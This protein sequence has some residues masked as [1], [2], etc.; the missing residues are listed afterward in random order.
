M[1][2]DLAEQMKALSIAMAD[3][4]KQTPKAPYQEKNH[5]D[6][7]PPGPCPRCSGDHWLR[8]CPHSPEKIAHL[9]QNA[10]NAAVQAHFTETRE[11]MPVECKARDK[12]HRNNP[13]KPI[14]AATPAPTP[15]PAPTPVQ[16]PTPTP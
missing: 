4:Q 15:S 11:A 2:L 3:I 12:N 14:V 10:S 16:H 8:F 13:I 9:L 7:K 1:I 6:R 5:S